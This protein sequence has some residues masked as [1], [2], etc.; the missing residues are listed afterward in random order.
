[1]VS[2]SYINANPYSQEPST[3]GASFIVQSSRFSLTLKYPFAA[4]SAERSRLNRLTR[5]IEVRPV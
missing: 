2:L 1:M 3:Y 5:P 4:P